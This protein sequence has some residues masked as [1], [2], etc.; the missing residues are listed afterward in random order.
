MELQKAWRE[1][2]IW[3]LPQG[4]SAS[5]GGSQQ[6]LREVVV[7]DAMRISGR[8][9]DVSERGHNAGREPVARGRGTRLQGVESAGRILGSRLGVDVRGSG[10]VDFV[11][12]GEGNGHG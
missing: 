7:A 4:L 8:E 9:E 3:Y 12:F 10:I 11:C 6:D 1:S 2:N 5:L